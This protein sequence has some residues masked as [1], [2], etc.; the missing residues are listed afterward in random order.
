MQCGIEIENSFRKIG[1]PEGVFQTL[2]GDSSIAEAL[3]DSDDIDA[4]TFTGSVSVGGKVAQ[5]ATSQIKNVCLN[6]VVAT[7]S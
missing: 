2:V 7:L 5:R 3:I 1:A 6:L 4:I